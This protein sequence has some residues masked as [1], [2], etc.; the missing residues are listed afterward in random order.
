MNER[1][2]SARGTRR[3]RREEAEDEETVKWSENGGGEMEGGRREK[4]RERCKQGDIGKQGRRAAFE[5]SAK[6]AF[7]PSILPRARAASWNPRELSKTALA[8]TWPRVVARARAANPKPSSLAPRLVTY[9]CFPAPLFSSTLLF[10]ESAILSSKRMEWNG[11]EE[12]RK[13]RLR[14]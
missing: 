10:D 3:R 6:S 14:G 13:I 11:A 7:Q 4:A 2:T 9:F 8:N 12:G 5:S 1:E